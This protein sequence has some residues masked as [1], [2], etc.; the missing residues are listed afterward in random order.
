MTNIKAPLDLI[1][2]VAHVGVDFGYGEYKLEQKFIKQA[3]ELLEEYKKQAKDTRV[4]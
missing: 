2:A 3:R 1:E 4:K